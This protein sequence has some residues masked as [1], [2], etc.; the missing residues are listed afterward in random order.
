LMLM[1]FSAKVSESSLR[2]VWDN[3]VETR[4]ENCRY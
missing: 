1:I 4:D 2:I 3:R